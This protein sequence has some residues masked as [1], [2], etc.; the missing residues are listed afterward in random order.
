MRLAKRLEESDFLVFRCDIEDYLNMSV[1]VDIC[2][3][4]MAISGAFG[5]AVEEGNLLDDHPMH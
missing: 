2:D 1:P 4:L 3:F 5:D